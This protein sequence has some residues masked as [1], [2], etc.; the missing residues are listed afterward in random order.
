MVKPVLPNP[1]TRQSVLY[2]Y[3]AAVVLIW[4]SAYTLM[5][6]TVFSGK[7]P[8]AWVPAVRTTLPAIAITIYV[9]MSGLKL[10][11]LKDP[12]WLWY[13]MMGFLGMTG[14]FYL[15]AKG[16][17]LGV[18]SGMSS[19]LTNGVTP[20]LIII[21]AHFLVKSE[22]LSWRKSIGFLIGFIGVAFL[23]LPEN[24]N[25]ELVA[26][27]QAQGVIL[28]VALCFALG[29]I[30]AKRAPETPASIGAA[31]MLVTA[32]LSAILIAAP[33][34]LPEGNFSNGVLFALFILTVFSTGLSDI[35]YLKVIQMSGP[36]MIGKINYLVPI[37]AVLFGI[38]FLGEKFSW[39]SVA[40]M[41]IIITGLL[42]AR[43]DEG[44]SASDDG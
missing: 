41:M 16:N 30:V 2:I 7:F 21:F 15:L 23:F 37:F 25:W 28:L 26:N 10:P 27:W 12:R 32:A 13:G 14:P 9:Y 40:A 39:R 3:V 19:I 11:P 20:L 22:Q 36:S 44:N 1:K 42:V 4:S 43:N 6:Y 8:A 35:L 17:E 24:L 5:Y 38:I 29:S 34:G 33:T 31:I 18:E